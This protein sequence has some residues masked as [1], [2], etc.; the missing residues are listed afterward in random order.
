MSEPE[1]FSREWADAVRDALN[2]GPGE[3]V[4]AGKLQMYWDFFDRIKAEYPASWS[5]GCRDLP[6]GPKSLFVQWGEGSVT[7]CRIMTEP[8]ATYVLGMGYADWQALHE[9]YDPQ[10]TVMYR[11]VLVEQGEILE[12][13][14]GIYFFTECLGVIGHVPA[15]FRS[16]VAA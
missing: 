8:S 11:K 5:L 3:S 4:K 15:S 7:D 14:K 6:G 16:V 9:G 13:F 2:A 10:R 12:F 1:F